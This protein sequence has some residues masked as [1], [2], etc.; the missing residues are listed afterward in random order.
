MAVTGQGVQGDLR[1][2]S[3]QDGE[4]VHQ[5]GDRHAVRHEV[6]VDSSPDEKAVH[7]P[8]EG[9][10]D[11]GHGDDLPGVGARGHQQGGRGPQQ[12]RRGAAG[13]GEGEEAGAGQG[14]AW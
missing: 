9:S 5:A 14:S 13:H 8:L 7:A 12:V 11:A 1:V 6:R 10:E 4:G 2:V 3:P